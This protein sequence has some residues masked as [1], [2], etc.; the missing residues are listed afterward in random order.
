MLAAAPGTGQPTVNGASPSQP[1]GQVSMADTLTATGAS[2]VPSSGIR[3]A[4]VPVASVA[5]RRRTDTGLQDVLLPP[6]LGIEI[7]N[8]RSEAE[9][10][11]WMEG[12]PM[13]NNQG[14]RCLFLV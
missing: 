10:I 2:G 5:K 9:L 4:A 12:S 6:G 8:I 11:Q 7:P 1:G 3:A 14:G 13:F